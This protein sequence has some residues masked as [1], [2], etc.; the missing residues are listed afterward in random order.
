MQSQKMGRK[1]FRWITFREFP[2]SNA[3]VQAS[4]HHEWG[5]LLS[6]EDLKQPRLRSAFSAW[7][8]RI[9]IIKF[10][11]WLNA[12]KPNRYGSPKRK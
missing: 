6:D 1:V 7:K 3:P 12:N 5:T 8:D 4:E 10:Y 2:D 11:T 9:N